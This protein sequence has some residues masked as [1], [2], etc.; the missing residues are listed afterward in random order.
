MNEKEAERQGIHFKRTMR[1]KKERKKIWRWRSNKTLYKTNIHND[2]ADC[3]RVTGECERPE[4]IELSEMSERNELNCIYDLCYSEYGIYFVFFFWG[5]W[6]DA[7]TYTNIMWTPTAVVE[8][9]C[10]EPPTFLKT[11]SFWCHYLLSG[12]A[13]IANNFRIHPAKSNQNPPYNFG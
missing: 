8:S 1:M 5:D 10:C 11:I 4:K 9:F 7:Y 12:V 6:R 2:F 3:N 13:N